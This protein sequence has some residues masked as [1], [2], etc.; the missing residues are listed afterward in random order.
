MMNSRRLITA[1]SFRR[2]IVAGKAD[3]LKKPAATPPL[4][5]VHLAGAIAK[6]DGQR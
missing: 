3:N 5:M 6:K 4:S 2:G 1:P